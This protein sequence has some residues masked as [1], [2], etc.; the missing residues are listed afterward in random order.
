MPGSMLG[1][2]D[3]TVRTEESC[4]HPHGVYSETGSGP[5]H[6]PHPCEVTTVLSDTSVLTGVCQENM[7]VGGPGEVG[8]EL[9]ALGERRRR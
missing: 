4:F 1:T 6:G 9:P 2:E 7:S 8:D 5:K 3:L